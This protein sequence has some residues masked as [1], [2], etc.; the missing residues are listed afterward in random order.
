MLVRHVSTELNL[1]ESAFVRRATIEALTEYIK[2]L[3]NTH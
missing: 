2:N 1:S 3:P